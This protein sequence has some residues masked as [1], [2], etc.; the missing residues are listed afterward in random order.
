[1]NAWNRTQLVDGGRQYLKANKMTVPE[2]EFQSVISDI[3]KEVDTNKDGKITKKEL[4]G[5]VFRLID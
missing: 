3:M 4:L 2:K 5:A 1:V